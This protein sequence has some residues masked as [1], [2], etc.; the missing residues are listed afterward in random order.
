[1][2][3]PTLRSNGVLLI[4]NKDKA[5]ALN[6]QFKSVFTED[7]GLV[8]DV[9]HSPYSSISSLT[10]DVDGVKKQLTGLNVSK[11]GGPDN[12]LPRILSV[13]AD[14]LSPVLTYIFQQSYDMNHLPEDWWKALVTPVHK[15]DTK[16]NPANYRPIY[17]TCIWCKI[18][19]HIVLS[20]TNSHLSTNDILYKNQHRF[21]EKLSCET[22]LVTAIH[23]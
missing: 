10:I 8:P 3:I 22:Q 21:R 13:L 6:R 5:Q 16:T 7:D 2:E 15:K 23:E 18:M 19:E 14:E 20:H 17:L 9:G 12:V 11:A 1:M 4:S